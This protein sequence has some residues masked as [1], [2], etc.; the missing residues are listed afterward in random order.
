M[1]PSLFEPWQSRASATLPRP[2]A[3]PAKNERQPRRASGPLSQPSYFSAARH[4]LGGIQNFNALL[5]DLSN[6]LLSFSVKG[7][8]S[9]LILKIPSYHSHR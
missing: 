5:T 6:F 9:Y 4:F 1:P 2:P 3:P 7:S 8:T